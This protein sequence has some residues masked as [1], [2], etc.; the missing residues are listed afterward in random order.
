[1][2]QKLAFENYR[3]IAIVKLLYEKKAAMRSDELAK[4]FHVSPR[5]IRYDIN[6]LKQ[7][8]SVAGIALI[9]KRG[10]GYYLDIKDARIDNMIRASLG[11]LYFY[12]HVGVVDKFAREQL[13]LRYMIL[14]NRVVKV[15]EL[16]E[17]F[18]ISRTTLHKD[19]M[20]AQDTIEPFRAKL[21][22]SPYHGISLEATE[23]S[24][25]MLLD[26]ETAF[27]KNK[28]IFAMIQE[29]IDTKDLSISALANFIRD[30]FHI[31]ISN[32]ELYNL[33][34]HIQI[35]LLRIFQGQFVNL[36]ELIYK[37]YVSED[38]V[39]CVETYLLQAVTFQSFPY[40]ELVYLVL[41]IK[42][43]GVPCDVHENYIN[44]A[45]QIID[46]VQQE[47]QMKFAKA[48]L[49]V[50][51]A[52]LLYPLE[53][54]SRNHIS[55]NPLLIREIKKYKPFTIDI[56]YRIALHLHDVLDIELFDNDICGLA[57]I[58][59][60][61]LIP[62]CIKRKQRY[63]VISARGRLFCASLLEKL[64]QEFIDDEIS[65]CDLH[66]IDNLHNEDYDLMISDI[67]FSSEH[68]HI[69]MVKINYFMSSDN[70]QAIHNCVDELIKQR[71]MKAITPLK[72][73]KFTSAYD[74][75]SWYVKAY[76]ANSS[77]ALSFFMQR[78]SKL[79][80]EVDKKIAVIIDYQKTSIKSDILYIP[81]G[82]LWKNARIY[83]V[84]I[85]NMR[86]KKTLAYHDYEYIIHHFDEY[87]K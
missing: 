13:I 69:P 17:L 45:K 46:N 25:R 57:H 68:I 29:Y 74:V 18:Y 34:A 14:E 86:H 19:L 76:Y 54:K 71:V 21:I 22:I 81:D 79:T 44:V 28:D 51:L 15:K 87:F 5:L 32:I 24:K 49:A 67:S 7:I 1:M 37:P 70:I 3:Q 73:M 56:A 84:M 77:E 38:E 9:A 66:D 64:Q 47:I 20:R 27:Y 39:R 12:D 48:Q 2:Q 59:Y 6:G 63:V 75:L 58:V 35:M 42:S 41:L 30:S 31:E 85:V 62:S 82:I 80:L 23:I 50:E 60:H 72:E 11:T 61:C 53:L 16:M 10:I 36:D 26:R 52:Q 8:L 78:E 40:A 65:Y 43:S 83:Y 33:H 4:Y 55:S